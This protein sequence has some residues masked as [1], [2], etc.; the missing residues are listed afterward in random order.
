MIEL[1][2]VLA[3]M[4]TLAGVAVPRYFASQDRRRLD[5]AAARLRADLLLA[6]GDA[7]AT[8][9]GIQVAFNTTTSKCTFQGMPRSQTDSADYAINLSAAPYRVKIDSAN[10]S[11][12]TT[13]TINGSGLVTN[14]GTVVLSSGG[15]TR[16]VTVAAPILRA[17]IQ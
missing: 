12:S 3:I 16:T 13:L 2:I 1:L 11:G 4:G 9:G 6:V 15:S 7:R 5:S 17:T 14:G 8:G 10:F